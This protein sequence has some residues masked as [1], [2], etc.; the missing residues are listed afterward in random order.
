MILDELLEVKIA[1][2]TISHGGDR[3][4]VDTLALKHPTPMMAKYTFKMRSYFVRMQKEAEK[5]LLGALNPESLKEMQTIALQS[6]TEVKATHKEYADGDPE[7]RESKLAEI[8]ESEKHYMALTNS[9]VEV[10]FN[11]MINDFGTMLLDNKRCHIRCN[12]DG[13]TEDLEPL[14]INIWSD[15][16]DPQDRLEATI[17]YCCFFGLTS[18]TR[19]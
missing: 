11:A 10:D 4:K 8:A 12:E 17:R 3:V 19:S 7:S 14:T 2:I 18:N 1:P 5:A 6:G 16:I 13:A 15:L 9:C